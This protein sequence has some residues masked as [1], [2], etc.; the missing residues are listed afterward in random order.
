MV[1][2]DDAGEVLD[3]RRWTTREVATYVAQ[4][5]SAVRVT[6]EATYN[7]QQLYEQLEGR[8]AEIILAHPKKVKAI[9]S[10]R[11]RVL[12]EFVHV[13]IFTT[14]LNGFANGFSSLCTFVPSSDIGALP[15]GSVRRGSG[16]GSG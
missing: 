10:A 3:Q 6:F 14:P 12:N 16:P 13:V 9:A 8:V 4:L 1:A 11:I 15:P 7:W 5:G 2:L